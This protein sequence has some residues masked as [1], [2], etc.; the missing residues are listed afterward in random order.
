[1]NSVDLI[2][3]VLDIGCINMVNN[4]TIAAIATGMQHSGIGIIRISGNNAEEIAGK[5]FQNSSRKKL[6]DYES[7]TI[8]YGFIYDNQVLIDEVMLTI[9]RAPRSFTTENTIEINCHG[10]ILILNKILEIVIKNGARA[11]EPGEF[12]K[13]AFLN[14]RIDLSK[15][16]AVMDLIQAKNDFAMKN[17]IGQLKGLL[18]KKI[19]GL[20]EKILFEVA[21]IESALDDPEHISLDGY[22]ERLIDILNT[23][24]L[25]IDLLLESFNK[26][27]Q[28]KEGIKT[29][30]VGKPNVGKSS[31]LNIL[32]GEEKAI[33]TSIAGTT[34]D[35]L[36][37]SI[38]INGIGLQLLDTAGIRNTDDIIEKIGV[39]KA[40]Q[41]AADADLILYIV[42]ASVPLD[43]NDEQ[44]IE[45]IKDKET[46]I[47]LNK[48]DLI[49]V[50]S[51]E[52]LVEK[53]HKKVISVSA[54]EHNGIDLFEKELMN[55]FINKN[56][57]YNDEVFI[58]NIRQKNA[59]EEAKES[60]KLVRK[61]IDNRVPEDFYFIDL[62]NAYSCLG[63]VIGE[64][65]EEDLV[66]E[67]F[68]KFCVGK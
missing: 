50:V 62:M 16:E 60:F 24:E 37:E 41:Y 11:A 47:L 28:L 6:S 22:S 43:D 34:R 46:I 66:N 25:E 21:F 52:H 64:N 54:K 32:I 15:A 4:D 39:K 36:E 35:V 20:R 31:L 58:T 40:I 27:K 57:S 51:E 26:G 33:V 14:G 42:D 30:I 56:V 19:V 7:H 45:I 13:R 65:V 61:S 63:K 38:F 8:H 3:T 44:I 17:S 68:S 18:F 29:V 48:T 55:M 1:M 10:G 5:I 12:T 67:I 53:V 49:S 9:M 59:I 23:L 2:H